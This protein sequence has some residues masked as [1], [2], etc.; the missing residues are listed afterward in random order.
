MNELYFFAF[1]AVPG[2]NR[3]NVI[4]LELVPTKGQ[5]QNSPES[6]THNTQLFTG[7]RER[8]KWEKSEEKIDCHH[9]DS[10][11][12]PSLEASDALTTELRCSHHPSRDRSTFSSDFVTHTSCECTQYRRVETNSTYGHTLEAVGQQHALLRHPVKQK[13]RG[14]KH[15]ILDDTGFV[16]IL[17]Y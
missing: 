3:K 9:Q 8:H 15:T 5:P 4:F 1:D 2:N 10:N 11:Q 17:S 14:D 12:G 16:Q 13:H 7:L 6:K